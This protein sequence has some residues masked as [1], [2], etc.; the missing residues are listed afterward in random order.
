M[1]KFSFP[2]ANISFASEVLPMARLGNEFA[3]SDGAL[4]LPMI[5]GWYRTQETGVYL[6]LAGQAEIEV[7]AQQHSL[8]KNTLLVVFPLQTIRVLG[9]SDDFKA[10][11]ILLSQDFLKRMEIGLQQRVPPF[12]RIRSCPHIDLAEAEADSLAALVATLHHEI[13]SAPTLHQREMVLYLG[14]AVYCKGL[15]Y[16]EKHLMHTDKSRKSLVVEEFVRLVE[17]HCEAEGNL[18]FYIERMKTKYGHKYLSSIVKE[19]LGMTAHE[20]IEDRR[21]QRA[22][23][24]FRA[25]PNLSVKE[26]CLRMT[27][28]S[29]TN[30]SRDFKR[31]CGFT[32]K[33]YREASRA[34]LF[35]GSAGK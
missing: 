30:F 2:V 8:C 10:W 6:C 33:E 4:N 16:I 32:P 12:I 20:F 35:L 19:L 11:L 15:S 27:F 7:E 18:D 28:E 31:F 1:E 29:P 24:L 34:G 25:S 14:Q 5:D 9:K 26:L 3:I 17:E 21:M 23:V 13:I 22:G